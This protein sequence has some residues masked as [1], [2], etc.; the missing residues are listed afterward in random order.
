M[1]LRKI[2][3]KASIIECNEMFFC[4]IAWGQRDDNYHVYLSRNVKHKGAAR[5]AANKFAAEYG[6]NGLQLDWSE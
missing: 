2:K 1:K 4:R 5:R 6:T 3:A